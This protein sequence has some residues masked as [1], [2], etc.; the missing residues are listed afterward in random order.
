MSK[1]LSKQ[2]EIGIVFFSLVLI[3]GA[4]Y[5]IA[6]QARPDYFIV[7]QEVNLYPIDSMYS[8]LMNDQFQPSTFELSGLGDLSKEANRLMSNAKELKSKQETLRTEIE[9]LEAESKRLSNRLEANRSN[10]IDEYRRNE[11]GP[12]ETKVS[13][14]KNEITEMEDRIPSN[15]DVFHPLSKVVADLRL[16]L[17][18]QELLLANRKLEVAKK[19]VNEYAKFAV[20][21]ENSAWLAIYDQIGIKLNDLNDTNL[22]Y[23]KLRIDAYD[24]VGKWQDQRSRRLGFI[25]FIYFSLGVSTT[26]TFGDIIPNHW[27]IRLL[28]FIQLLISIVIVGLFVNSFSVDLGKPQ[29]PTRK[30][31]R[32]RL[33]VY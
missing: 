33:K 1:K 20:P 12:Y 22:R 15:S 2:F 6:W 3:S 11:L 25:D 14:L 8:S 9:S 21:E 18:N 19:I 24:L 32:R 17:A 31:R 28:V 13:E 23:G 27:V 5:W 10:R 16:E 4:I 30:K 26:T 29:T 7:Q